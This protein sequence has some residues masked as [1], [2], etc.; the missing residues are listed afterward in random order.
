MILKSKPLAALIV[1]VIFGSIL[2]TSLMGWWAT[3]SS[4]TPAAY[5]EGEFAGQA[6]PADIRGSYTF[7]DI[8]KNFN[9]SADVLAQAFGVEDENPAAFAVKSLEEIYAAS[10]L[11]IGTSSM[12]LFV[13]FYNS[14]PFDL[15]ADIYLP[16]S[17]AVLLRQRSLTPEQTAYLDSHTLSSTPDS[18]AAEITPAPAAGGTPA[19][20]V[21]ETP[22]PEA[23]ES[24]IK[25]KTTF[26]ELLS[27]GLSQVDIE[28]ALGMPLP[29]NTSQTVK[30]F[31]TANGLSFETIKSALQ[32]LAEQLP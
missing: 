22:A 3:E 24:V 30:D 16:E 18:P 29:D 5:T 12:R 4:K 11:E 13:A 28:Q 17:A 14:L 2:F 26:A 21:E 15:S 27:W 23:V 8:E 10:E 1:T 7:G 32:T 6:N 9:I 19:P 25:G 20:A 31:C